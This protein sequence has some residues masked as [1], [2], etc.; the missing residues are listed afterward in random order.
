MLCVYK[1]F[2]CE[3]IVIEKGRVLFQQVATTIL[4]VN[5]IVLFFAGSQR[6]VPILHCP[7]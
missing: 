4:Q 1:A 7:P 6:S 3:G 2:N 5:Y